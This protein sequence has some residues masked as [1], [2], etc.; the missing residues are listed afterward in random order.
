MEECTRDFS[1]DPKLEQSA[2]IFPR[3]ASGAYRF[4]GVGGPPALTSAQ[5][6][7]WEFEKRLTD[8]YVAQLAN[9]DHLAAT[10]IADTADPM[11]AWS[12]IQSQCR[13]ELE[14]GHHT[15]G[16]GLANDGRT[17][18]PG[19]V[20]YTCI[21]RLAMKDASLRAKKDSRSAMNTNGSPTTIEQLKAT[22][23]SQIALLA[24]RLVAAGI[25]S[26]ESTVHT[27][28]GP[29]LTYFIDA[30]A[31]AFWETPDLRKLEAQV[32]AGSIPSAFL[33]KYGPLIQKAVEEELSHRASDKK[34]LPAKITTSVCDQVHGQLWMFAT[35]PSWSV[36]WQ[37]IR[38]P[39]MLQSVVQFAV[40]E[41]SRWQAHDNAAVPPGQGGTLP[42]GW[43]MGPEGLV[44]VGA[45]PAP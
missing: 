12:R 36:W 31:L 41:K 22:S 21:M 8:D 27:T 17:T 18:P 24:Q 40:R 28:A 42:P 7:E 32:S 25:E 29:V 4:M 37:R 38:P 15:Q 20:K 10:L 43:E 39:P 23:W 1:P 9:V 2:H 6:A 16:N 13:H 35:A 45:P 14:A 11:C 30:A 34:E 3:A 5:V 19:H 26:S 33:A 44:Q